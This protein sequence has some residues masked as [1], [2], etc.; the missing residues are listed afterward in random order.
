VYHCPSCDEPLGAGQTSY[1]VVVGKNTAFPGAQGRKW[2]EL[3]DGPGRTLMVVE[4]CRA[5]ISWLEP[6]DLDFASMSYRIDDPKEPSISSN[7]GG[8]ACVS[9]ADGHCE[10]VQNDRLP[11]LVKS[12]L[13][14]RDGKPTD[15]ELNE[16]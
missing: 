11:D 2:G 14:A 10:S 16:P 6:R 4:T 3:T 15:E 1:V 9:F 5:K 8:R 13:D 12:M 7:H